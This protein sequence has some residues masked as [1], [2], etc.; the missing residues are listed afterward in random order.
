M[1][2]CSGSGGTCWYK[3]RWC[4]DQCFLALIVNTVS[5]HIDAVIWTLLTPGEAIVVKPAACVLLRFDLCAYDEREQSR[6]VET[7]WGKPSAVAAGFPCWCDITHSS[8][9]P[10]HLSNRYTL[11]RVCS[12]FYLCIYSGLWSLVIDMPDVISHPAAIQ[13]KTSI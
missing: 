6:A 3:M 4:L 10:R 5:A 8:E 9:W 7:S 13:E 12:L 2:H 1:S 11:Y